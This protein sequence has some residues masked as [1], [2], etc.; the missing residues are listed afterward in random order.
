MCLQSNDIAADLRCRCP[1]LCVV[2]GTL[3]VCVNDMV[4]L[5]IDS[6]LDFDDSSSALQSCGFIVSALRQICS[7]LNELETE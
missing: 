3:S 1:L 2:A 7:A 5:A 4:M 6:P